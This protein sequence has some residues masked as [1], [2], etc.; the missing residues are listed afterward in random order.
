MQSNELKPI[1]SGI[2]DTRLWIAIHSGLY[3]NSVLKELIQK[4]MS[5]YNIIKAMKLGL[6]SLSYCEL[7]YFK[8][9]NIEPYN[10][11]FKESWNKFSD[12]L[13]LNLVCTGLSEMNCWNIIIYG[14]MLQSPNILRHLILSGI[15]V[16]GILNWQS[17]INFAS[18]KIILFLKHIG[19][20]ENVIKLVEKYGIDEETEQ[21]LIDLG[22]NEMGEKLSELEELICECS[23]TI[24]E[25]NSCSEIIENIETNNSESIFSSTSIPDCYTIPDFFQQCIC[26]CHLLSK[27]N[28]MFQSI[29]RND[30]LRQ[31]VMVPLSWAMA[32]SLEYKPSNPIHFMVYQLL[33]WTYNNISEIKKDNVQ[34][35]IALSTIKMDHKLIV[36]KHLKKKLIENEKT[37]D[38]IPC[39]FC[40]DYQKLYRI[41]KQY[42]KCVK[43]LK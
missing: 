14:I 6:I 10:L 19:I 40:E 7:F 24:L 8:K 2:N 32:T 11:E 5:I 21:M 9:F 12:E 16:P 18:S 13:I 37:I 38:N 36:K 29:I 26:Q 42:W 33:K 34:Q 43:S 17:P 23:L 28:A 22:L 27:N 35:L 15:D 30:Y 20:N 4:G 25:S 31:N 39:D 3:S 41:K 1:S